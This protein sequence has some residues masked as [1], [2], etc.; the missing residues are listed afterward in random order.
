MHMK[1]IMAARRK[2]KADIEARVEAGEFRDIKP[3]EKAKK[4]SPMEKVADAVGAKV[5]PKKKKIS[6]KKD[7]E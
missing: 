7:G 1:T 3:A 4:R 6:A 2:L 5:K